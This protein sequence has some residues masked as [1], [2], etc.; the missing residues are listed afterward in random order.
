MKKQALTILLAA[1]AGAF[2]HAD[3]ADPQ[4]NLMNRT[5]FRGTDTTEEV[6][7]E[8][9]RATVSGD[10][11]GLHGSPFNK[12]HPYAYP[13]QPRPEG[14]TRAQ[15]QQELARAMLEGDMLV[16]NES[17]LTHREANPLRYARARGLEGV[18]VVAG[19]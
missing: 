2:A 9:A 6:R 10:L 13:A 5:P 18:T 14:L 15:V 1:L 16:A 17:G 8:L 4:E 7:T 12:F 11:I 19:E 3:G